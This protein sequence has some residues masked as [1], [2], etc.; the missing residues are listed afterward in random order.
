MDVDI[1]LAFTALKGLAELFKT[2]LGSKTDAAAKERI[3]EAFDKVATIQASLLDAQN[4]LMSLQDEKRQMGEKIQILEEK[5]ALKEKMTFD[6]KLYW[7]VQGE[8]K[9]GPYCQKCWD[10]ESLP[11][12][13]QVCGRDQ[14]LCLKCGSGYKGPNYRD[15]PQ[16]PNATHRRGGSWMS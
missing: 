7:Q 15:S 5:L 2:L 12:R 4:G 6:G 11:I 8:T 16:P 14:W 13:L 9:D 1:S 3:V 10:A